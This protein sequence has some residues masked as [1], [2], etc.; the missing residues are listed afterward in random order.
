MRIDVFRYEPLT[1]SSI[2]FQLNSF[3]NSFTD[4]HSFKV[5][6]SRDMRMNELN[7]RPLLIFNGGCFETLNYLMK[8][9]VKCLHFVNSYM[10]QTKKRKQSLKSAQ[11]ELEITLTELVI[12]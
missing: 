7:F 5:S 4:F 11:Y 8:V 12:F 9:F 10:R 3:S 2:P 6:S 1:L